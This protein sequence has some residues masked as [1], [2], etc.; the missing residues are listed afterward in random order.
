MVKHKHLVFILATSVI[1]FKC[2][3][4]NSQWQWMPDVCGGYSDEWSANCRRDSNG[5]M[6]DGRTGKVYDPSGNPIQNNSESIDSL[7]EK[8]SDEKRKGNYIAA[9]Q[10]YKK[11]INFDSQEAQAYFNLGSIQHLR[12]N[13]RAAAL[14]NFRTAEKLFRQ[15]GDD[16]MTRASIENIHE[17]TGR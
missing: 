11:I 4:A 15:Q 12:L 9:S 2:E 14:V 5:N 10:I 7:Y 16:Y 13:D 8:A 3:S 6:I 1:F 17:L